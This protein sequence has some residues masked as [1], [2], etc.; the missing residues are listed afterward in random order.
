[1]IDPD[2]LGGGGQHPVQFVMKSTLEY[3][4]LDQ[5]IAPFLA[6]AKR[7]RRTPVGQHGPE[8]RH[9]RL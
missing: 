7:Y 9:S 1:M 2:P 6:E 8:P 4:E 5:A 3:L